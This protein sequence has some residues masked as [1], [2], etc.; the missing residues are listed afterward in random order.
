M[1][2][3]FNFICHSYP[4]GYGLFNYTT[5]L[6]DDMLVTGDSLKQAEETKQALYQVF[7]IKDLRELKYFLGIEFVK[8][9]EGIL[10][11][12]RKYSFELIFEL[13]LAVYKPSDTPID[14]NVKLTTREYDE[15]T[16]MNTRENPLLADASS[17]Q[18]LIGK[19]LYLTVSRPDITYSVQP[20][21]QYL[22]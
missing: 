17:Y 13:G 10:M 12:Q 5:N 14:T 2:L 9:K 15:Y 20:L 7:K 11:S 16:N 19:I 8:S 4:H 18:K 21:S 1:A 6:F 3:H 22:Q